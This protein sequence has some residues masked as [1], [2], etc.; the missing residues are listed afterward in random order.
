[1]GGRG[2]GRRG[3][4]LVAAALALAACGRAG[5]PLPPPDTPRLVDDADPERARVTMAKRP[6]APMTVDWQP[7][8]RTDLEVIKRQGPAVVRFDPQRFELLPG[9]HGEGAYSYVGVTPKEQN[10]TLRSRAELHTNLPFG[11]VSLEGALSKAGALSV[12]MRMVGKEVLDRPAVRRDELKGRC[13]GATHYVQAL[14]LGAFR[15]AAGAANGGGLGVRAFGVGAQ[16]EAAASQDTLQTDGDFASCESAD[17]GAARAPARCGAVLRIEI[18]PLDAADA[19]AGGAAPRDPAAAAATGPQCGE[20]TRW[21][22]EACVTLAHLRADAAAHPASADGVDG[23]AAPGPAAGFDCDPAKPGE[24]VDQCKLGNFASC[25]TVGHY[26]RAGAAGMPKDEARADKLWAVACKKGHAPACT[27]LAGALQSRRRWAEAL[28]LGK[29]GCAGGDPAGCNAVAVQTFFGRGTPE[30][31]AKAYALWGRACSLRDWT[32]CSNAGVVLRHGMSGVSKDVARARKLFALACSSPAKAGC[33]NLGELEELGVAG[34]PDV[35]AAMRRY[36]DACDRGDA[37]GCVLAG[38][39][40]EERGRQRDKALALFERG[41]QIEEDGGG[42]LSEAEMR[43]YYAGTYSDE[44]MHRRSCDGASQSALACYN[45][46]VG[47]ERG[48]RGAADLD[49]A[50]AYLKKACDAGLQKACRPARPGAS[51]A[52]RS[53]A[54]TGLANH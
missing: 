37:S 29:A 53:R 30:D 4:G 25:T 3:A 7:E 6:S 18:V 49:R 10:I 40:A 17:P 42:C 20:G 27:A 31:R 38:L 35:P 21:N 15:F 36:L 9:C 26:L 45:A 34:A 14:T 33:T 22:G 28:T 8:S 44:S 47:H 12:M 48:Y 5:G 43:A 1:V 11:A 16:G 23:T 39:L 46:G 52:E 13:E 24:C 2:G 41:C 19:A 51:T 32:S 54:P 50:G